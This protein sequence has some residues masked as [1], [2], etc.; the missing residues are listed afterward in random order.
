MT[1]DRPMS[2]YE[3]ALFDAIVALGQTLLEG[4]N[5]SESVLLNKLSEARTNFDE[6]G[7]RDG[8]ATI[9]LLMKFIAEPPKYYVPGPD[10]SN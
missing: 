3:A 4:G 8:A 2:E 6:M 9:A 7:R 1:T 5:I 10:A